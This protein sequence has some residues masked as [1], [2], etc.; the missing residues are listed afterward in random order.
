MTF[1]SYFSSEVKNGY[2]P[3]NWSLIELTQKINNYTE[4]ELSLGD[5]YLMRGGFLKEAGAYK[6][7]I[8]DFDKAALP[9]NMCHNLFAAKLEQATFKML[10]GEYDD[11]LAL[12]AE[13][14]DKGDKM[15]PNPNWVNFYVKYA[16]ALVNRDPEAAMKIADKGVQMYPNESD[17]H[18][19]RGSVF[20]FIHKIPEAIEVRGRA[21]LICRN[22][23]RVCR[24]NQI[25][26]H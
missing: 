6:E 22:S 7:A 17:L 23:K 11:A 16:T 12:F 18:I 15:S 5:L 3:N 1:L 9:E 14:M 26:A 21:F 8:A 19:A 13:L 20:H 25:R 4:G 10:L 24:S 2:N